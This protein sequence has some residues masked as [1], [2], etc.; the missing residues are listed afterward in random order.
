[1]LAF[2]GLSFCVRHV[3]TLSKSAFCHVFFSIFF[4]KKRTVPHCVLF[5]CGSITSELKQW[6]CYISWFICLIS[7][8]RF[9]SKI[10]FLGWKLLHL[11][12]VFFWSHFS[13]VQRV[14]NQTKINMLKTI[15]TFFMCCFIR[16]WK[17]ITWT[18]GRVD[19]LMCSDCSAFLF[20]VSYKSIWDTWLNLCI[21]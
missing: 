6:I 4:N 8:V 19:C 14:C 3:D 15:P 10:K 5:F 9:F 20:H 1:M 11:A 12:Y 18:F 2:F 16:I 21:L 17:T 13:S 7:F